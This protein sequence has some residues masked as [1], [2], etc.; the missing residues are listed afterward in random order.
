M[1]HMQA[2]AKRT[3]LTRWRLRDND[4]RHTWHYLDNDAAAK[5]WPQ[6]YADKYYLGLPL[7]LPNLRRATSSLGAVENALTFFEKLQLPSGHWGCESGGAMTFCAGIVIAWY[8]TETVIPD[9]VATELQ[10]YLAARVN[11]QDGGWG[12]HTTGDSN[13][14]GTTLNYIVMRIA[15]MSPDHPILIRAREFVHSQ[16]GAI[17]SS[18]WGKVWMAILGIVDWDIVHPMPAELWLLP[19]WMPLHPRRFFAEMRLPGQS[20]SYLYSKRWRCKE[21]DLVK[22]LRKELLAQPYGDIDW[23]RHRTTLSKEDYKHYRSWFADGVNWAYV[24]IW[25]PYLLPKSI[26][27]RAEA[28]LSELIDIQ[29]SNTYHGGIAATDQPMST[30]ISFFRDGAKSVSLTK[31]V[32]KIQEFLWMT[33]DGMQINATNGSQSWD[34]AFIVQGICAAGLHRDERWREMCVKALQFFEKQQIREDCPEQEKYYRQRR[35]GCW[36]F[37]NKYQGYGV[38]D[39]TAEAIKAVINLQN[40]VHYPVLLE[41]E[42]IF[43]AV[44]SLLL[45]QNSTGGVSAFEARQGSTYLELLNPSEIFADLMVES[46]FPECTSSCVTAL[47][48]F[49]EHWPHYRTRDI[50]NFIQRG[51]RWIKSDQ[52]ADGSWYGFWGICYTY[53]AMFGLEALAAVGETYGNSSAARA[54]CDFLISK[55]REDGGWSESIQGCEHKRYIEDPQGSLVV[56]TAWAL[57]ALMAGEYPAVEPIKR[58]A[59][60]LMSRQQNNGEW[61]EEA[62]PGVFHHFCS[63][64]YPNYKFSFTIRALGNFATRYPEEKIPAQA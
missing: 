32:D 16:G 8:V 27:S 43:D 33:G 55:Q 46:D 44:D 56:Q 49:R 50:E 41:D 18:C 25:K 22:S 26:K 20:M 37:S 7:D 19:D 57:I 59:Q 15:G 21:T 28:W 6:S 9:H 5:D 58:G 13:I 4:S 30:I 54:A 14:C 64:S 39:C 10:A 17:Y 45:Y 51:V 1:E 40:T 48:L 34:T 53:G 3:D 24:N 35:K 38:S 63:F 52:R 2:Q 60:F 61:L 23:K 62:I 42:R 36:A 12:I 11:P 47:T 29:A 31:Y